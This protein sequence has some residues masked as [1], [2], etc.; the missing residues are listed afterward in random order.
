MQSLQ[1]V[2]VI[3]GLVRSNKDLHEHL[4]DANKQRNSTKQSA[5]LIPR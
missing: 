2:P 1:I 3:P 5:L 4:A